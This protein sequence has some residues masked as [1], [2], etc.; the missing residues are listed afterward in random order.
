MD[1]DKIKKAIEELKKNNKKRKFSQ[2]YDLI[3]TLQNLDM[4][5]I[6]QQ[7]DFYTT[8]HFTRGKKVKI[9]ALVGPELKDE[10]K[11]VCDTMLTVDDFPK[12]SDKKAAKKLAEEHDYFV[13]QAN[14]MGKVAGAFGKVLG[15]RGKM[16]NP[17]AGCVVPPKVQLKPLYD[18]LQKTIRIMAKTSLMV[19]CA[20]GNETMKDEEVI[21]NILTIY[22]QLVHHLPT[23]D[24]NIRSIFLKFTMGKPVKV[25]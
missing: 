13:A 15:P 18:K 23:H 16:P 19:Q 5:K 9:C 2:S 6:E 22:S 17:K 1:K 24:N 10:A 3:I 4:K 14:I 20:V 8:L 12:Y 7:I 11:D 21:D 25:A